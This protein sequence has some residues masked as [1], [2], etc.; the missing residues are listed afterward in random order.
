[1]QDNPKERRKNTRTSISINVELQTS[2]GIYQGKSKNISFSGIY[3]FCANSSNI[4]L[5]EACDIKLILRSEPPQSIINLRCQVVRTD[6]SGVGVKFISIDMSGYQQFKNLMVY[7]SPDPDKL[8]GE[9]EKN[10]GLEI[11]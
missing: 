5:G 7:N 1:M 4:P 3:I 11:A 8:L 10:P 6:K 2:K 9:L